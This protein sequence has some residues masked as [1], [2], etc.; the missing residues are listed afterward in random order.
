M[1]SGEVPYLKKVTQI[2]R[3]GEIAKKPC[4]THS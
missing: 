3:H 1:I 2:P 4:V